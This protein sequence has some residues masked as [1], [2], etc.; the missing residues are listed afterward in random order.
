MN[1]LQRFNRRKDR[2]VEV[3]TGARFRSRLRDGVVATAQVLGTAPDAYGIDHVRFLLKVEPASYG[4][5][6]ERTLTLTS[7]L[8]HYPESLDARA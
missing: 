4:W 3:R 8:Q 1:W 7:F 5:S 6:D 2:T